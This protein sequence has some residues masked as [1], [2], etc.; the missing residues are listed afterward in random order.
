MADDP[1]PFAKYVDQG[2]TNPFAK[3]V[4]STTATTQGATT[5]EPPPE[6]IG[7]KVGD[8][9]MGV[10]QGLADPFIG[11]GQ[12]VNRGVM[13][14]GG[15]DL[16]QLVPGA[17]S[18][19]IEAMRQRAESTGYGRAGELAGSILPWL[20]MPEMRGLS[21]LARTA[22]RGTVPAALQPVDPNARDFAG[23]K[24]KQ[25]LLGTALGGAFETL[26]GTAGRVLR[27]DKAHQDALRTNQMRQ[28]LGEFADRVHAGQRADRRDAIAELDRLHKEQLDR[29]EQQ[30]QANRAAVKTTR[31]T[32]ADIPN[33]T[34][35][36]WY[37]EALAPIGK[38]AQAPAA[39]GPDSLATVRRIVGDELN[40]T[41][42]QMQLAGGD[43]VHFLDLARTE[44]NAR[45]RLMPQAYRQAWR[46]T[47]KQYVTDPLR[48]PSGQVMTGERLARWISGMS[49][50]AEELGRRIGSAPEPDRAA[51]ILQRDALRGF[52]DHA[53]NLA[54]GTPAI[55]Q[56]LLNG[57][58]AY[59]LWSI[60]ND[61]AGPE[62][63]GKLSPSDL[64]REWSSR[65]KD[66][67]YREQLADPTHANNRLM[68][69]L[70]DQARLA[71]E[72]HPMPERPPA[73]PKPG[74]P[75]GAALPPEL[76]PPPG[77]LPDVPVPPRSRI[78]QVAARLARHGAAH[79]IGGL[80]AA[81]VSVAMRHPMTHAVPPQ[82]STPLWRAT[83]NIAGRGGPPSAAAAGQLP[84]IV[85]TARRPRRRQEDSNR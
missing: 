11:G 26:G 79:T 19:G 12:L 28:S 4:P 22:L 5:Q 48:L 14:L 38:Q 84:E 75:G 39:V 69:W 74:A 16:S 13:A 70:D 18:R 17:A 71:G 10:L 23:E 54:A 41:R 63:L 68:R 62:K 2:S 9:G 15:P 45:A 36:Q 67:T 78:P 82:V 58:R 1:N 44:L 65:M 30:H 83:H 27:M 43:R 42:S 55:R 64:I 34:A 51:L 50:R 57:K 77:R 3:Y 35:L 59:S 47:V 72:K 20:L 80:P 21:L 8:V 66:A 85:V 37:Q 61:A 76:Q 33:Q 31:A 81:A 7:H 56:R 49:D 53:E 29:L 25:A 73:P 46:D 52:I 40:A 24:A 32:Q 60:A 6:S